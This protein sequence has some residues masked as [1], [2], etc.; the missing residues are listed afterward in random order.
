MIAG[1]DLAGPKNHKDTAMAIIDN[2]TITIKS[3]LS[4]LD[5]YDLII[6]C[7][8]S[9]LGI[10]APLS[11]S[12]TGGYRKSDSELR[13]FLNSRGFKKIGV[14]APTFSR[15]IYLTSRG[16][17]LTRLLLHLDKTPC[18]YEAHPGAF[19]VLDDYPYDIIST[20]KTDFNSIVNITNLIKAKGYKFEVEPLTDH[21]LMSVGVALA[22]EAQTLKKSHWIFKKFDID[23]YDFIS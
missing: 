8:I 5:I 7:K 11:Y 23:D 22:V 13:S 4:D 1:I 17:R 21:E 20:V 10:D 9:D 16:I 3:N 12:E 19:F 6:K 14:M 18:I 15:M 2:K